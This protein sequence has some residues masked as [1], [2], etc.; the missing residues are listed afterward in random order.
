[1]KKASLSLTGTFL[2]FGY[3][4]KWFFISYIH[5]LCPLFPDSFHPRVQ[6]AVLVWG[7]FLSFKEC[8]IKHTLDCYV[9]REKKQKKPHLCVINVL[10]VRLFLFRKRPDQSRQVQITQLIEIPH[11]R[12]VFPPAPSP[13]LRTQ[14]SLRAWSPQMTSDHQSNMSFLFTVFPC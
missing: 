9:L 2:Y 11:F 14:W 12:A 10:Q 6:M 7:G 8:Q 4:N 5:F 13:P 1:M 3:L